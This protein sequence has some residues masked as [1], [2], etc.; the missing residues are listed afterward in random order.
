MKRLILGFSLLFPIIAIPLPADVSVCFTPGQQCDMRIINAIDGAH[1]TIMVQA[2]QL[3]S[4]PI[5]NSLAR[6][7]G[8]GVK[9]LILLDKTQYRYAGIYFNE[10][11]IP[12]WI[13]SKPAI[14]HNKVMIIDGYIVITGSYNFSMNAQK[15]NAENM[16]IIKS[17]DVAN[18]YLLNFKK[19]FNKSTSFN[20]YS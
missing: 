8:R 13:D 11:N 12:V 16:V 7:H 2:Y 4:A 10:K 14:A 5:S 9:V 19:R 20:N 18:E 6:A 15:R 1:S 3:T 17:K